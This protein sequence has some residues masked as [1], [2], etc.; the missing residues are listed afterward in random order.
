M[1][2]KMFIKSSIIIDNMYKTYIVKLN[3]D[4]GHCFDTVYTLAESETISVYVI[5]PKYQYIYV[6][7]L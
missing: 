6:V 2:I 5:G 3:E 4:F 1:I 7:L